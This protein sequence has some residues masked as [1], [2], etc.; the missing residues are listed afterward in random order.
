MTAHILVAQ[1]MQEFE[2]DLERSHHRHLDFVRNLAQKANLQIDFVLRKGVMHCT[3]LA[4]Q[5]ARG[6]D[7]IVLGA[8]RPTLT[9]IDLVARERQLVLE[10]APC[11]VL[12]VR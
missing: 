7:V 6:C 2:A 12:V 8:Y 11:P 1:E 4:E 10:E 5:K 3:V 9:K